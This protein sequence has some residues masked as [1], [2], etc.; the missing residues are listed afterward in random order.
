MARFASPEEFTRAIVVGS[1]MRRTGTRFSDET[2]RLMID[3]VT[4]E[5]Q[6]YVSDDGL[7]LPM[8]AHLATA[9]K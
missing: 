8:E 4:V 7:T 1:I 3:D 9:R 5:L 6:S 2:I